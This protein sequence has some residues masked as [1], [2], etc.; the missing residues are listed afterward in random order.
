MEIVNLTP[1]AV[2][3]YDDGNHLVAVFPAAVAACRIVPFRAPCPELTQTTGINFVRESHTGASIVGAP[4]PADGVVYIVSRL[5]ALAARRADFVV[6]DMPVRDASGSIVGC[7]G[8]A[9]VS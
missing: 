6:P 7:R 5:V 9:F 1:H 3:L 8:F 4:A 2:N